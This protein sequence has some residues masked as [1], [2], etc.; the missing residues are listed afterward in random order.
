MAALGA[1]EGVKVKGEDGLLDWVLTRE[2]EFWRGQIQARKLSPWLIRGIGRAM[3]VVTLAG[4][5]PK[6][7]GVVELLRRLRYFN[8][9]GNDVLTE[10]SHLLHETYPGELWV[11]PLQPDILGEHLVHRET[12][13][14][15]LETIEI[16]YGPRS[17]ES[18]PGTTGD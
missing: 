1:V 10:I 15:D 14:D 5:V 6:P 18:A 11:S 4:G 13:D 9:Q 2:R 12:P 7:Q 8:G 3:A 16:V 17:S